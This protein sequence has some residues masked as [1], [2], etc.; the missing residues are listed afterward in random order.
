[1]KYGINCSFSFLGPYCNQYKP[2]K[3][4]LSSTNVMA[5]MFK[6]DST[7]SRRGFYATYRSLEQKGMFISSLLMCF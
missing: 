3:V 2:P 6:A 7:I 4:V 1:M 5:I